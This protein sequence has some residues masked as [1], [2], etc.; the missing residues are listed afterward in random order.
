MLISSLRLNRV[1]KNDSVN[2]HS[3]FEACV[4]P[5]LKE[6]KRRK[7]NA[8]THTHT[9]SHLLIHQRRISDLV[10]YLRDESFLQTVHSLKLLT[11]SSKILHRKFLTGSQ[12]H[13]Y[14]DHSFITF[15]KFSEKLTFLTP[16]Y[17]PF[18]VR[19]SGGKKC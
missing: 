9:K 6:N 4:R 1:C 10:K 7:T 12:V 3:E 5:P 16:R 8:H 18:Y 15:T 19:I 11:I 14:R 13:F 17:A 2:L